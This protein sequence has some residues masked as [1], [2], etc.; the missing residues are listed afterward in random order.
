MLKKIER[1][2]KSILFAA[3]IFSFFTSCDLFSGNVKEF[4]EY[5]TGSAAVASV[6]FPDTVGK[7]SNGLLCI[8]SKTD[9]T[10]NL[11]LRNPQGYGKD[12]N[13][14]IVKYKFNNEYLQ[15]ND[16]FLPTIDLNDDLIT[17]TMTFSKE[18]LEKFDN[19]NIKD[20]D[21]N[22]IKDLSGVCRIYANFSGSYFE[23]DYPV[24]FMVNSAPERIRG[25]M[26]QITG[27]KNT[28]PNYV[29]A[30]NAPKIAGTVH[31]ADTHHIYIGKNHWE[32]SGDYNNLTPVSV[33]SGCS[34]SKTKPSPLYD[35]D[36]NDSTFNSLASEGYVPLYFISNE[37]M[38]DSSRVVTYKL[39]II[40]DYGLSTNTVISNVPYKLQPPKFSSLTGASTYS[41]E[42]ESEEFKFVIN[43]YGDTF[44]IA[45]DGTEKAGATC[46]NPVM[47]NYVVKQNGTV[48]KTGVKQAPVTISLPSAI[49]YTVEAY[50]YSDGVIDSVKNTSSQFGVSRSNI[51][52][53]SQNAADDGTGSKAKPYKTIEQ[54]FNMIHQQYNDFHQDDDPDEIYSY[55]INLLS[56]LIDSDALIDIDGTAKSFLEDTEV[57]IQGY[58]KKCLLG[59]REN[60]IAAVNLFNTQ[61]MTLKLNN[62]VITS[63]KG[64]GINVNTDKKVNLEMENVTVEKCQTESGCAGIYFNVS[65]DEPG[66]L[67]LS[68]CEIIKN[69]AMNTSG[70]G[71][72]LQNGTI[73]MKNQVVIADNTSGSNRGWEPYP[74]NLYL[75]KDGDIQRVIQIEEPLTKGSEIHLNTQTEPTV[76]S[77]VIFTRDFANKNPS[78]KPYSVF[79]SDKNYTVRLK[80][81]EV[82][83]AKGGLSIGEPSSTSVVLSSESLTTFSLKRSGNTITFVA[84]LNDQSNITSEVDWSFKLV[85]NG[86]DL[87]SFIKQ[88][89]T[90]QTKNVVTFINTNNLVAGKYN[91]YAFAKYKDKQYSTMVEV[92]F[93]E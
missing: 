72:Y 6:A 57:I 3:G 85:M 84:K 68:N 58:G 5:Y 86:D 17:A 56:D 50:A 12:G 30:F 66:N 46:K 31:E 54:C 10:F 32:F 13:G 93:T 75:T 65:S 16:S 76:D 52:Y 33:E 64:T 73:S 43:H 24:N 90:S 87:S 19:G 29:V 45:E 89:N 61:K 39:S 26:F 14:I 92:T 49:G 60:D 2:I 80:G 40:D 4:L 71:I 34:L 88:G 81:N 15:G 20:D 27:K 91:L 35:L 74:S 67:S 77:P 47:I 55:T 7:A 79:F 22:I 53:V 37:I 83:L 9:K 23:G 21:N 51:Y 38:D 36:D 78:L 18:K 42:E 59:C 1:V 70:A 63:K 28:Q 69:S 82:V 44:Y 8:D 62:L 11:I 48:F 25:A 41:A